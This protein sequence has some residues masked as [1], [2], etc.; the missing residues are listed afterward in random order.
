MTCFWKH[1]GGKDEIQN[2]SELPW[3]KH[4][5]IFYTGILNNAYTAES[6]ELK[7]NLNTIET[8]GLSGVE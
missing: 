5:V 6:H 3:N 7:D 1:T 4:E 2:I 8:H